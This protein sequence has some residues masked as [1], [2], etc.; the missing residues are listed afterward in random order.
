MVSLCLVLAL[1]SF[2]AARA[3]LWS[4]PVVDL[5][6]IVSV[7]ATIILA[8]LPT[9]TTKLPPSATIGGIITPE[10]LNALPLSQPP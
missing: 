3:W 4:I 2:P 7:V 9:Q 5:V 10:R 6:V 1:L 8:L